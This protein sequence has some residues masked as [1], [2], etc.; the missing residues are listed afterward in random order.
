MPALNSIENHALVVN[1]GRAPGPPSRIW[2]KRLAAMKM[3]NN[4][5]ACAHNMRN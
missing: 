1:T 4:R 3:Q 2:P 5:K